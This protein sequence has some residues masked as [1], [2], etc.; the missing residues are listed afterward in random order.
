MGHSYKYQW[1]TV[2]NS[3]R[4]I[5]TY[6]INNKNLPDNA[7][8]RQL[9]PQSNIKRNIQVLVNRTTRYNVI[10]FFS[11]YS[12]IEKWVVSILK[13]VCITLR[14]SLT[15]PFGSTIVQTPLNRRLFSM[16]TINTYTKF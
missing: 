10:R 2:T 16:Y 13:I 5:I 3:T 15:I 1:A 9:H 6:K 11:R 7:A 8:R 4:L 14:T 12:L